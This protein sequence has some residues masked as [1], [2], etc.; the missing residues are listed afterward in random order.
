ML[1]VF[2]AELFHLVG[3][4][5]GLKVPAQAVALDGLGKDHGGLTVV[6]GGGL[7]GGVDLAV[8][9]TATFEVPQV[10]VG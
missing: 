3:G 7:V 10:G 1:E 4:V 6:L 2:Q 5:A 9:V 8:V